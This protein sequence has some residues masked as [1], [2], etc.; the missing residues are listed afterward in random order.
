MPCG[1]FCYYAVNHT[2]QNSKNSILIISWHHHSIMLISTHHSMSIKD[3][4][5]M[6]LLST[7]LHVKTSKDKPESTY[8]TTEMRL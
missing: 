5:K 4:E 2:T 6:T 1:A 3:T 7:E 8:T